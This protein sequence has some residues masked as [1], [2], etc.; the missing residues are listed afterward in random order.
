MIDNKELRIGI[1][2]KDD[3]GTIG[4][5]EQFTP[6]SYVLRKSVSTST[7]S[8]RNSKTE[9]PLF[10]IPLSEE[11]LQKLGWEWYKPLAH[12][13]YVVDDVWY[14]LY[15]RGDYFSFTFCNLNADE[16]QEMPRVNIKTVHKLQNLMY[17]IYGVEL[18]LN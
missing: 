4:K 11:I 13:R 12:W 15:D 14:Q 8:C 10:P 5:L 9:M 7:W 1:Y 2:V 3:Y 18:T 16:S 17:A 6:R